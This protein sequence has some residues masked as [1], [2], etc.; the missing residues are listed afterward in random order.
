MTAELVIAELRR[1]SEAAFKLAEN[2]IAARGDDD[3]WTRMPA[4]NSRCHVSGFSRST[5]ARLIDSQ[6]IRGKSVGASRFYSAA[7]IR[8]HISK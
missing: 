3:E 4:K 2:L 5:I 6:T 8:K 7:D 1:A